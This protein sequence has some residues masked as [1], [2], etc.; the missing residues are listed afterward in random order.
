MLDQS[1]ISI[2][3]EVLQKLYVG[4]ELDDFTANTMQ[5][6]PRLVGADMSAYN[7][8]NYAERRM[9]AIID[10]QAAQREYQGS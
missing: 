5:C 2:L 9:S 3:D 6:R 8:L 1:D 7:E 4:T 10:N